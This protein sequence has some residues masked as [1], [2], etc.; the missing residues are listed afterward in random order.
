MYTKVTGFTLTIS[1][2][3]AQHFPFSSH[4]KAQIAARDNFCKKTVFFCEIMGLCL[5][6][7]TTVSHC[8]NRGTAGFLENYFTAPCAVEHLCAVLCPPSGVRWFLIYSFIFILPDF[9]VLLTKQ[10]KTDVQLVGSSFW[11]VKKKQLEEAAWRVAAVW[12]VSRTILYV[13]QENNELSKEK[14]VLYV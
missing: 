8:K 3:S 13:R 6:R 5:L 2:G 4:H 12:R 9:Y 10:R 14:S 11:A 7:V 1:S